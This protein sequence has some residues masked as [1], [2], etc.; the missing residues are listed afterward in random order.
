[1]NIVADT[2]VVLAVITNEPHKQE[3]VSLTRGSDLLAPASLPWELGNAFSAMF[4]R[5]RITLSQARQALRAYRRIPI[6][7]CDV[8]LDRVLELSQD[9]DVYAYDAYVV[10]CARQHR[11]PIVSLDDGLLDASRR[12]NV[13]V[14]E[15][16]R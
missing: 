6:R 14:L 8:D 7:L 16:E 13:R 12:A 1:M 11:C 3:L 2:S 15:V 5:G 4:K 10:V 9:L